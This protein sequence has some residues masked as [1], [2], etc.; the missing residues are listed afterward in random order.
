[1]TIFSFVSI[2]S[3]CT[4]KGNINFEVMINRFGMVIEKILTLKNGE[5]V[6]TEFDLFDPIV[7]WY[8]FLQSY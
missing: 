1:M 8:F 5:T 7:Y 3:I 6:F 4:T 2:W